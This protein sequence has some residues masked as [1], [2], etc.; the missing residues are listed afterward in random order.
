MRQEIREA[1]KG[2][3]ESIEK[4]INPEIYNSYTEGIN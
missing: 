4:E 3:Y 1:A 2:V